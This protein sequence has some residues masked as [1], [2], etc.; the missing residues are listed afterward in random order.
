M[1][2]FIFFIS[3][4]IGGVLTA[5]V[6][7]QAELF[8]MQADLLLIVTLCCV[9][10]EDSP[11][12][13]VFTSLVTIF[14]DLFYTGSIGIYTI[15]YAA[16]CLIAMWVLKNKKV[17]RIVVPVVTCACAWV[18]KDIL[19]ALTVFL[20]GNTFNFWKIFFTGTLPEMILNSVIMLGI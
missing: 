9:M 10:L 5:G 19:S 3:S 15:P 20:D 18:V 17:D 4:V 7:P 13:I 1:K 6:S 8:G 14:I 16:V 12:P 2:L 11:M